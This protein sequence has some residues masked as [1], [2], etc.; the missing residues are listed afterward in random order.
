[1]TRDVKNNLNLMK[2][3]VKLSKFVECSESKVEVNL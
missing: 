3:E 1:M 2:K